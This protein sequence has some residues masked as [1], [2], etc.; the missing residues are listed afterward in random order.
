MSEAIEL[1]YYDVEQFIDHSGQV[2]SAEASSLGLKPGEWPK[3]F[4][5][6]DEDNDRLGNGLPFMQIAL[7]EGFGL[8]RQMH[9]CIDIKVWND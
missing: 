8:Y 3:G 5:I 2:Y 6:L 4:V 9:G 1:K 7:N